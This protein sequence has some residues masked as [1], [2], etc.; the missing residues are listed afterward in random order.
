MLKGCL[1]LRMNWRAAI[2]ATL[3]PCLATPAAAELY[4]NEIFFDPGGAGLDTRDEYVELR[5]TPGMSLDNHYL[6]LVENEGNLAGTGSTGVVEHIFTLGDNRNTSEF[7]EPFRLGTNGFLTLRQKDNLYSA[8]AP[9]TTDLVNTG[10]G[11]GWG[12]DSASSIRSS[13]ER[14]DGIVENSGS[15]AFLIRNDG[16]PVLG[17]PFLGLDLD[18]GND[19]LDGP[20]ND[21]FGWRDNWTILDSIGYF[22]EFGEAGLGRLYARVNFGPEIPG[23]QL[24]PTQGGMPD[25]EGGFVFQP[26]IEPGAVYVGVNYEIEYLGRWGNSEGQS[27][28]DWHASNLTDRTSAGSSGVPDFRQSCVDESEDSVCHQFDD[29][30]PTTP[31]PALTPESNMNVP[32]GTKLTTTLGAP[33]YMTGDYS[34]DGVVDAADYTVWRDTVGV[35]GTESAHPAADANHDFR[36]DDAD[37]AAWQAAYGGPPGQSGGV[38]YFEPDAAPASAT[39]EPGGVILALAAAMLAGSA[40]RGRAIA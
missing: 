8:P 25:G 31:A 16:D 14:G 11:V 26:N 1:H 24:S 36:V 37:Y 40:R 9:G 18:V 5:G 22:S 19:G 17:Q 28:D 6:I 32:Y 30:D 27:P 21:Q 13:D 23:Q 7:E 4:I 10:S 29:G 34:G 38:F 12:S 3:L 33:N 35:L 2:A 15:T 39:P 20:E